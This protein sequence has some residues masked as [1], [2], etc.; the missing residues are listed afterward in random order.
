M[1]DFKFKAANSVQTRHQ[2]ALRILRKHPDRIPVICEKDP[3]S[4]MK[5]LDKTKYLVPNDFS[6]LQFNLLIR[7]NLDL[8]QGYAL[9]LIVNKKY[10]MTGAE[11]MIEVY[12][13]HKD[14]EDE[15][16]YINYTSEL[17]WG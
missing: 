10:A 9:F 17:T 8:S 1:S 4:K 7:K 5:A 6:A 15:F 2:E 13:K 11:T 16:L 12:D 14:K 3:K